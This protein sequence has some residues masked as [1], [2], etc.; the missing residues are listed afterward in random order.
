MINST[1]LNE[2]HYP[3][4]QPVTTLNMPLLATLKTKWPNPPL[5]NYQ[6]LQQ[7]PQ[8]IEAWWQL[9]HRSMPVLSSQLEDNS[10][11]LRELEAFLKKERSEKRGQRSFN[12][13]P[14][15]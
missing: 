15:N 10:R 6:I 8:Q 5:E 11:E 7:Q 13:S 12:P 14:S 1:S 2:A 3:L 9:S 4:P